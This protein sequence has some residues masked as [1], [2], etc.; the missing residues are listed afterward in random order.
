[1]SE[2]SL[3]DGPAQSLNVADWLSL[4]AMPVFTTMALLTATIGGPADIF[5]SAA[6]GASPIDGMTL[7]YVLMSAFHSAPWIGLI[8]GRLPR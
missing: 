7:M 5:C 6:R 4:A 8:R 1:M 2:N 3:G